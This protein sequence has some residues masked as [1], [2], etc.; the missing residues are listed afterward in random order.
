MGAGRGEGGEYN[1]FS[2]GIFFLM[3]HLCARLLAALEY[4]E[5]SL[6]KSHILLCLF[7]LR[8]IGNGN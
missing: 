5:N 6:Q 2:T 1:I 7:F 8:L 4:L 3:G